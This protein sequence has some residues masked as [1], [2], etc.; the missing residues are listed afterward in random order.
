MSKMQDERTFKSKDGTSYA[1]TV[2]KL[3][4]VAA[5]M[6]MTALGSFLIPAIVAMKQGKDSDLQPIV[7]QFF[8]GLTPELRRSAML[9]LLSP[10]VVV[11]TEPDGSDTKHELCRGQQAINHAFA[12]D[13]PM[14]FRA[15]GFSLEVN[16]GDFFD[17]SGLAGKLIP[18]QSA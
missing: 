11:R 2:V 7:E 4:P 1:M 17:V 5:Y 12:G 3:E 13:V 9:D 10:C 16:F 18:T 15:L 6:L 8:K 14:M